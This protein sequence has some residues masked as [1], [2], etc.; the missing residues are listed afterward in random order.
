MPPVTSFQESVPQFAQLFVDLSKFWNHF[1]SKAAYRRC[2]Q[3]L[4]SP[5]LDALVSARRTIGLKLPLR[6]WS[7]L[8]P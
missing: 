5:E 1:F 7:I 6:G 3:E 8:L 2:P 4:F